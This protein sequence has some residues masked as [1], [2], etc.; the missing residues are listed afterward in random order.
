MNVLASGLSYVDLNFLG[1]PRI[2][3]TV[4][5]HGPGGVALID[6]DRRGAA[7]AAWRSG[8]GNRNGRSPRDS[9]DAHFPDHA[10]ATG[11][12]I[13]NPGLRVY[14]LRRARRTSWPPSGSS[15]ARPPLWGDR[16]GS[17]LWANSRRARARPHDPAG[18][19]RPPPALGTWTWRI[20]RATSHH[21]SY[22]N[23]DSGGRLS[24]HCRHPPHR[25][26]IRASADAAARHRPRAVARQ[27]GANWTVE[28]HDAVR[29]AFR[30][31]RAGG[32]TPDG[33]GGEPGSDRRP[34]QGLARPRG[35]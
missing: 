22:H 19:E 3:A 1:V 12:L 5:L 14:V 35:D 23:A 18:G 11:T 6:P 27:P 28:A 33:D 29:H 8:A 2:I 24:R 34:G 4:V 13:Q 10:G 26:R 21:V 20:R 15:P 16:S 7:G 32:G 31:A 17:R 9:A 30:A 25:P